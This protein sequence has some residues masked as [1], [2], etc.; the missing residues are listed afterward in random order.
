MLG[1][2]IHSCQ[3]MVGSANKKEKKGRQMRYPYLFSN[4]RGWKKYY[5]LKTQAVNEE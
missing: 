4:Q 1:K 5:L 3:Q 2:K